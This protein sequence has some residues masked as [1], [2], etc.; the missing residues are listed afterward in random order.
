MKHRQ[1]TARM[2]S[3]PWSEACARPQRCG[4]RGADDAAVGRGGLLGLSGDQ[5]RRGGGG[6]TV[7]E[8][9]GGRVGRTSSGATAT[10]GAAAITGAR[11][12]TMGESAWTGLWW[13]ASATPVWQALPPVAA[14]P[15]IPAIWCWSWCR[16]IRHRAAQPTAGWARRKAA[17]ARKANRR[18]RKAWSIRAKGNPNRGS[19]AAAPPLAPS[20]A[21]DGGLGGIP[22]YSVEAPARPRWPTRRTAACWSRSPRRNSSHS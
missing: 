17:R 21:R 6:S 20:E 8:T 3:A 9:G 18:E 4:A 16:W 12:G 5:T 2:S 14:D 19:R 11:A 7:R 22:G 15:P 1:A 13:S 10:V